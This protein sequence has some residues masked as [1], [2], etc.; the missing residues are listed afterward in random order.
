M[1]IYKI[2]K[3][4]YCGDKNVKVRPTPFM[5]DIGANM[6]EYCWNETQKEYES[7]TGEC[8]LDF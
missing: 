8:I 2:D 6:C 7:S 4:D 5:A 1:G 3:C